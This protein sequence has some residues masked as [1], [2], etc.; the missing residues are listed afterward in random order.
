MAKVVVVSSTSPCPKA[1]PLAA[2]NFASMPMVKV[3]RSRV[4]GSATRRPAPPTP[5]SCPCRCGWMPWLR[6]SLTS[7]DERRTTLHRLWRAGPR[8]ALRTVPRLPVIVG[9][10]VAQSK[11]TAT[12]LLRLWR[13]RGSPMRSPPIRMGAHAQRKPLRLRDVDVVCGPCNRSRG[14]SR[15]TLSGRGTRR[16]GGFALVA[17]PQ[18]LPSRGARYTPSGGVR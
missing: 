2:T 10:V 5:T 7:N 12:V 8:I 15:I 13:Y 11:T 14:P 16:P 3:S 1:S 18:A 17:R 4:Q 6:T 9:T